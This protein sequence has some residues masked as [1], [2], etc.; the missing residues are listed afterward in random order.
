[1]VIQVRTWRSQARCIGW[2]DTI[3]EMVRQAAEWTESPLDSVCSPVK[4]GGSGSSAAGSS[5]ELT[6]P[7]VH[8]TFK[9]GP[10]QTWG[11]LLQQ[12]VGSASQPTSA[13]CLWGTGQEEVRRLAG[14]K[15]AVDHRT[16]STL[17]E[18]F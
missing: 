1:M 5:S 8:H 6:R 12:D 3:W 11:A 18:D 15:M 16:S 17:E 14:L 7:R 10:L 2:M 13:E 4:W 9:E